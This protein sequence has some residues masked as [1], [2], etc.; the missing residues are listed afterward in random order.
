MFNG[1]RKD[2]IGAKVPSGYDS[3]TWF[4]AVEELMPDDETI[5]SQEQVSALYMKLVKPK[6]DFA[7]KRIPDSLGEIK[8]WFWKL[9]IA[10]LPQN[11]IPTEQDLIDNYWSYLKNKKK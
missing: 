1:T 8:G 5:M 2:F 10:G 4:E 9:V 6:I 7:A 11:K 3:E